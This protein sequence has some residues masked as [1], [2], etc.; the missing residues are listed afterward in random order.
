MSN[1]NGYCIVMALAVVTGWGAFASVIPYEYTCFRNLQR[2]LG[3]VFPPNTKEYD[4]TKILFL[5]REAFSA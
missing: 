4:T 5:V 3:N 1:G 2:S